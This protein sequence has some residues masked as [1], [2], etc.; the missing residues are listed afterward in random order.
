V[1]DLRE[2]VELQRVLETVLETAD[3]V[4][5]PGRGERSIVVRPAFRAGPISSAP[6]SRAAGPRVLDSRPRPGYSLFI[7]GRVASDSATS[8]LMPSAIRK[9]L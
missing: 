9:F 2:A 4:K 1:V 8:D 7:R 6:R 5:A 3:R